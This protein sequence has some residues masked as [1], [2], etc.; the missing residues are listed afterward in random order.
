ME[1]EQLQESS[2]INR[3]KRHR[4]RFR[5]PW[6]MVMLVLMLPLAEWGLRVVGVG[7]SVEPLLR[8]K[9]REQTY[10]QPNPGFFERIG[11]VDEI[12][13]ESWRARD[14]LADDEKSRDCIR[15][16]VL[17]GSAAI[18]DPPDVAYGFWR[19]LDYML[20]TQFPEYRFEVLPM[21]Y[22]GTDSYCMYSAAQAVRVL[23]PDFFLVY[24]GN[25]EVTAGYGC[26][27]VL[28]NACDSVYPVRIYSALMRFRMFQIGSDFF[29]TVAA[30]LLSDDPSNPR[31]ALET[32][33]SYSPRGP[34][35]RACI[36]RFQHNLRDICRAGLDCGASVLVSTVASNLRTWEPFCSE[37][38]RNWNEADAAKWNSLFSEGNRFLAENAFPEAAALYEE[39]LALD[40]DYAAAHFYLATCLYQMGQFEKAREHFVQARDCDRLQARPSSAM[41]NAIRA[42]VNDFDHERVRLV[43]G[44]GEIWE[45]SPG[46]VPGWEMFY[47]LV[48]LQFVGAYRLAEAFLEQICI[49]LEDQEDPPCQPMR[50]E[51][52]RTALALTTEMQLRHLDAIENGMLHGLREVCEKDWHQEE[53]A[54]QRQAL[55]QAVARNPP[56]HQLRAYQHALKLNPGDA[57]LRYRYARELLQSENVAEAKAVL[58]GAPDSSPPHPA[59]DELAASLRQ[60]ATK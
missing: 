36:R 38:G 56:D 17:G 46:G 1:P 53:V 29:G 59:L 50:E 34:E 31:D 60:T 18:G 41:N 49:A 7:V 30:L 51:E 9:E 13:T 33:V 11:K 25:N 43:E 54:A 14:F 58:E 47:D 57:V 21:A 16:I 28:L 27:N 8:V 20:R 39:A 44:E 10:W 55:Q 23:D 4:G 12:R 48:H 40:P 42:T 37:H 35:V 2:S 22:T 52:V 5:L 45:H 6:L 26:S 15:L 19:I 3:A 32:A 24:M